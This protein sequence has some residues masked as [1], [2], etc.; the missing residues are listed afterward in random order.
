MPRKKTLPP[1]VILKGERGAKKWYVRR[2]FPTNRRNSNNKIIYEEMASRCE[3]ETE[4]RAAEVYRL[5][6]EEHA[7][8]QGAYRS[9]AGSLSH[10][11]TDWLAVARNSL[12]RRT[13]ED[14]RELH[15]R[16]VEK[17]IGPVPLAELRPI[18]VQKFYTS[19]SAKGL[20]A[21]VVRKVHSFLSSALKQAVKWEYLPKNPVAG[22]VLPKIIDQDKTPLSLT[23]ARMFIDG[24]RKSLKYIVFEFALETGLRPGEYLALRWDEINP[25]ARTV[26]VVRSVS[27]A[28]AGGGYE[29]KDLKTKSSR[30]TI[31]ISSQLAERLA[32]LK[33]TQENYRDKLRLK[34]LAPNSKPTGAE[35][36]NFQKR[37]KIKSN[38]KSLLERIEKHN[39]VFPASNGCPKSPLNLNRRDFKEALKNAKLDED[40]FSLYSLRHTCL[41]LLS[42]KLNPKELQTVAGH[43]SLTTTLKFYVHV[44]DDSKRKA[45]AAIGEM[46]Y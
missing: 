41:T 22:L 18:D 13:H 5:L 1:H 19:L 38:L 10:Y 15:A 17:S 27:F 3:P 45:T 33:K 35:G 43:S 26:R 25:E 44:T 28:R 9:A 20:S 2:T 46:L 30:R 29:Y 6:G 34:I 39:L 12:A 7:R 8:L 37:L 11:L 23:E 14:Y 40:K 24:C 42:A 21:V 31:T 36:V 32:E 4:E 16:Y